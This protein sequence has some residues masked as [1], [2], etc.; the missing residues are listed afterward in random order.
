MR[1]CMC[2]A[3]VCMCSACVCVCV[4]M[5]IACVCVCVCACSLSSHLLTASGLT[6]TGSH[7]LFSCMTGHKALRVGVVPA[8]LWAPAWASP[9]L[10]A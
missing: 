3:C 5:S 8:P 9:G 2:T 4:H 1:L 6:R 10:P 7:E